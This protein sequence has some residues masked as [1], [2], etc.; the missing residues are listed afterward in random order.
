M[1]GRKDGFKLSKRRAGKRRTLKGPVAEHYEEAFKALL[2]GA[3]PPPIAHPELPPGVRNG[4]FAVKRKKNAK[5][6]Q[7]ERKR[8]LQLHSEELLH[9]VVDYV[10]GEEAT[11]LCIRCRE[12]R[13]SLN[14][15][16]GRLHRVLVKI[17]GP[18]FALAHPMQTAPPQSAIRPPPQSGAKGPT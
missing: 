4:M 1:G 17:L 16:S 7:R 6:E 15:D 12:R 8:Q 3:K 18:S 5:A 13:T 11:R 2:G 14:G 9:A 10:R